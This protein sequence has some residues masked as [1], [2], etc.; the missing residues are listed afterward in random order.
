M[1]ALEIFETWLNGNRKD[2][3]REIEAAPSPVQMAANCLQ[4]AR[5]Y[6]GAESHNELEAWFQCWGDWD[7]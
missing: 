3:R 2:A 4:E 1:T 6:G 7:A 5:I